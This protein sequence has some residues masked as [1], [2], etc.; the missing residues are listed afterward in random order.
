M[1]YW[2]T[3]YQVAEDLYI[4][5]PYWPFCY[6]IHTEFVSVRI[7]GL[8]KAVM[9]IKKYWC[10]DGPSGP[11]IDTPNFMEPSAAHDAWY[12]LMR[13]G[14]VPLWYRPYADDLMYDLCLKK[15]MCKLRA[16]WCCRAVKRF[17]EKSATL[18]GRRVIYTAP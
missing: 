15:E 12:W 8:G 3:K 7:T 16:W 1:K 4:D 5:I 2:K 6:S 17:A 10:Y 9:C 13:W 11:A 14:H 18:E